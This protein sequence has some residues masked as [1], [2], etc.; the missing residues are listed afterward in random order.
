M[1]TAELTQPICL[2]PPRP[3]AFSPVTDEPA[4]V[5]ETNIDDRSTVGLVE[6]MLKGPERLDDITRDE[7]RQ[8]G[9]VTK[10]LAISLIGFTIFGV[11]AT[12]MLNAGV[13][14]GTARSWP[15]RIPDASWGEWSLANLTLAYDI[16]L[17]AAT[18]ICLPSFY[19]YGLLA[20]VKTSM[21]GVLAH[22]MKG[23]SV[24]AVTLVGILPIYLAVVLGMIVF[25][26]PAHLTELTLYGA[27]ALPFVAGLNGVRSLY[28][29]FMR[30]T[31]TLPA[32]R[33]CRRACLLRR[34][35]FAWSACYTAVTPLMV[36]TI[37]N[38]LS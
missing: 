25:K 7:T 36:Y 1:R 23:M 18:G 35:V 24:A 12:V 8:A 13:A 37:W 31:D 15:E 21:L 32:N 27:L 4:D 14:L 2:L 19:F 20:G 11:A 22:A 29:G 6:L 28:V 38:H 33:R 5:C 3:D 30:L 17:I 16:G 10:F 9:L 34:L 26:L